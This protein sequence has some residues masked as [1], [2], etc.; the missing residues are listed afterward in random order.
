MRKEAESLYLD[1]PNRVWPT[2]LGV[3]IRTARAVY[4]S[5]HDLA[6]GYP[7]AKAWKPPTFG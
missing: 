2:Q 7:Q 1:V 4:A 6:H 5:V 3:V